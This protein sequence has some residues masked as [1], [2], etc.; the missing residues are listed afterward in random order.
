M[1]INLSKR[2]MAMIMAQ[3]IGCE[4]YKE[5]DGEIEIIS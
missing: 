2:N 1:G 5:S 4:H 3:C